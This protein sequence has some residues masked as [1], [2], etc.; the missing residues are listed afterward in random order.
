MSQLFKLGALS[1]IQKETLRNLQKNLQNKLISMQLTSVTCIFILASQLI[2]ELYKN[3]ISKNNC[4]I[5]LKDFVKKF[6]YIT[7]KLPF[8]ALVGLFK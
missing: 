8:R 5:I 2:H 1:P 3:E 6:Q 4:L 7:F